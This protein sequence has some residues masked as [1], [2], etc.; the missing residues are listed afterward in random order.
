MKTR[1]TYVPHRMFAPPC[2]R[3]MQLSTT[4]PWKQKQQQKSLSQPNERKESQ[5]VFARKCAHA[6]GE[7][8][9]AETD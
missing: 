2:N 5:N 4:R 9:D 3:R 6:S 7:K 1:M 8:R